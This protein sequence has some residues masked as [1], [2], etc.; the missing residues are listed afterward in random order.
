MGTEE[1]STLCQLVLAAESSSVK[2][3]V[4]DGETEGLG[5]WSLTVLLGPDIFSI[6]QSESVSDGEVSRIVER[7]VS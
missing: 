6:S 4:M 3:K 2:V 7:L 5:S 1:I